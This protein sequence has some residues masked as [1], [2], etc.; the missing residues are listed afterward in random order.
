M[1]KLLERLVAKQ[2]VE[3]LSSS[4]LLPALQSAYR[5]NHSTE[6]AVLKV[7]SDILKAIDAGN[8]AVLALL[9]LSAAFDTVD[10]VTLLQRLKTTYGVDGTVLKW[11]SSYLNDRTQFV[12][13]GA[14]KS[15]RRRV[16]CGVPQGSVLGPI[17]FLL[18]TADLQRVVEQ[19]RLLPHL[20]ADD[21]QIYGACSP[22]TTAEFQNRVSSCVDDVAAWMQ[23]NR[24]Q[25]NS[26]KTEVLWCASSRRQHQIPQSGTRIGADD[27]MP[28]AFVRD[29]GIYIDADV[30]MR[31]HVAKT[32]SSCFAIL[33]HLRS[34][35]RSVSQPVMQS[36]VVALVLTRLDYGNATLAGLANQLLVKL[37]SV[38]NAAARLI[39]SSRKF[40]HVTPLLRELH[41]LRFPERINYKL[42]LLVF[43][44]LNGLAPPYLASEFRRVADTESRQRLRSASTA[45]LI[46]PRVRRATIG[47]RAFPVVAAQ[48]WNSLPSSVTSSSS[49]KVFKSRLKTELFT[50]CYRADYF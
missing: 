9:D 44:C 43:K 39:F 22:S 37:Q 7:L 12:R 24:L 49:L 17:L 14:S 35:R 23:S 3:Y 1:S 5:A 29:L 18:Y 15:S 6:T 38:L 34:I 41:W 30:S 20:Y 8:L 40:D 19:H 13:C 25:L 28:S 16:T 50:R 42:A 32:V 47:G 31:T 45:E 21:T 4:G 10:H 2:L 33:R 11:I 27:V 26:A 46:I 36:L 48:V